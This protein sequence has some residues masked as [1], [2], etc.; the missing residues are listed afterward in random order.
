[1]NKTEKIEMI[2][3]S[4]VGIDE[5]LQQHADVLLYHFS[6][7]ARW[8]PVHAWRKAVPRRASAY[9]GEN[10]VPGTPLPTRAVGV[11]RVICI[12]QEPMRI[13]QTLEVWIEENLSREEI[14]RGEVPRIVIEP[15]MRFGEDQCPYCGSEFDPQ[16]Y[17][18]PGCGAI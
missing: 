17:E 14:D 13:G 2:I 10:W 5:V 1:M 8:M 9:G 3:A 12:G 6:E 16:Y 18:C 7:H 4:K 11:C 15:R